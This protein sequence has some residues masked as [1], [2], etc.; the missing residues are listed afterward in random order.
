[1]LANLDR[2]KNFSHLTLLRHSSKLTMAVFSKLPIP[3]PF[4]EEIIEKI[5][6]A[7]DEQK[8]INSEDIKNCILV[9]QQFY[10]IVYSIVFKSI[11]V[12]GPSD[13]LELFLELLKTL[14]ERR[15]KRE[16]VMSIIFKGIK[17]EFKH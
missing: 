4:L 7:L 16:V 13:R 5:I 10:C 6:K 14:K 15:L 17:E 1:M 3:S 8:H 2:S 11:S 9:S 12:I